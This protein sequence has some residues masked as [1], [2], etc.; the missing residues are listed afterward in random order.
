LDGLQ[1]ALENRGYPA[2]RV[3]VRQSSGRPPQGQRGQQQK[4]EGGQG[5]GRR[6]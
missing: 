6:R 2:A 5:E 3:E 4:Q 1:Q